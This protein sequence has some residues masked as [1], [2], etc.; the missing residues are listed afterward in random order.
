MCVVLSWYAPK[1]ITAGAKNFIVASRFLFLRFRPDV[2]WWGSVILLR[3]L[4]LALSPIISPDHPR[5]QLLIIISILL[6][7]TLLQ[8]RFWPWR[9]AL[10]NSLDASTCFI[11][12]LL[13]LTSTAFLEK[14]T[15]DDDS[16]QTI[17]FILLIA[18][19]VS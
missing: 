13:L 9:A 12:S 17:L 2:W 14:E 8:A 15:G 3:N 5:V 6:F 1:L 11:L 4:F 19:G 10:L 16:W 7:A 18:L